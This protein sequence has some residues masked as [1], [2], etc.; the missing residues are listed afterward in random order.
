MKTELGSGY[1][2]AED[3]L[4]DGRWGEYTL[5]IKE[6]HPPMSVKSADGKPID[7]PV[8]DFAETDKSLVLNGTNQRLAKCATG[9]SKPAEWVGKKLTLYPSQ[10]NWFGQRDVVAIR[11]RVP[12]GKARPF[13]A[14][15][16]LGKDIT[17]TTQ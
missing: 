1:L 12:D 3:F 2:H 16:Q 8:V 6:V 5:E 14:P 15:T 11:I 13:V 4:K 7:R 9:T 17:G 10:G